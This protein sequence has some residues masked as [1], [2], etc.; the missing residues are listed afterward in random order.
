MFKTKIAALA[1]AAVTIVGGI[2]ATTHQAEARRWGWGP[3]PAVGVG[4]VA[5]ALVGAAIA[6]NA[7]AGPVYVAGPRRCRI[8]RQYNGFGAWRPVRVCRW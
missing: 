4:L 3:G 5:G 1:I 6:S 7:Y 2:A 8:V